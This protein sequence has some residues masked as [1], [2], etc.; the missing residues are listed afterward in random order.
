MHKFEFDDK[1]SASNLNKHD[2]D[3]VSAQALWNDPDLVEVQAT[4]DN[5]PRFYICQRRLNLALVRQAKLDASCRVQVLVGQGLITHSYRVLRLWR[6]L[7]LANTF[8]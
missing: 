4:P 5:E 3:F 2:I 6:S 8:Q 1:K 7:G